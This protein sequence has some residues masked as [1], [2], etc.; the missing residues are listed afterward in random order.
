[1]P[2][3]RE[4]VTKERIKLLPLILASTMKVQQPKEPFRAE[5]VIPQL[6][7]ECVQKYNADH[8][9]DFILGIKYLST[10]RKSEGNYY[11]GE[12]YNYLYG[13]H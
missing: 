7:T 6:L 10:K 9:P 8:K 4:K 13:G 11:S 5:Y 1:M 12:K 2:Q 3:R